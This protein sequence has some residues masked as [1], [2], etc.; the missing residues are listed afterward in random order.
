LNYQDLDIIYTL[1]ALRALVISVGER[2]KL[3][4]DQIEIL[5]EVFSNCLLLEKLCVASDEFCDIWSR[6]RDEVDHTWSEISYVRL[7]KSRGR[8]D[9]LE[10]IDPRAVEK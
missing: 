2:K 3:F 1:P 5:E 7:N 9:Y 4:T 10:V 6:S 8:L